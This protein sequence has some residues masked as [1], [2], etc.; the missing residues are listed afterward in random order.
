MK[1]FIQTF[2]E[3]E[4]KTEMNTPLLPLN[5]Y[6]IVFE[7]LGYQ[8]EDFETNGWSCDFWLYLQKDDKKI[9]I[10][11]DLWYGETWVIRKDTV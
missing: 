8:Q 5:R 11:G 1:E 7:E 6:K 10:T 9:V 3:D 2:L 4:T